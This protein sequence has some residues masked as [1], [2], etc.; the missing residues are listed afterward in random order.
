MQGS[1][2]VTVC[3]TYPTLVGHIHLNKYLNITSLL[4]RLLLLCVSFFYYTLELMFLLYLLFHV[5]VLFLLPLTKG[6]EQ[7]FY[8]QIN[9]LSA[10][11]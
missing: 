2:D 6:C 3:L 11:V 7:D 9:S 4:G 10:R 8:L 5:E 1:G